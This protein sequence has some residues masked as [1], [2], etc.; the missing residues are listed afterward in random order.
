MATS[1]YEALVSG[2]SRTVHQRGE[3]TLPKFWRDKHELEHGDI[4]AVTETDDGRL[5]VIPPE[6]SDDPDYP[7]PEHAD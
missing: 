7:T 2:D 5:E 6:P 3:I 4:V 1:L